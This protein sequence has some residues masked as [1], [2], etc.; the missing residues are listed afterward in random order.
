MI[1]FGKLSEKLKQKLVLKDLFPAIGE[2][3]CKQEV[4]RD[5]VL[6]LLKLGVSVS[7]TE[8]MKNDIFFNY[9]I[10]LSVLRICQ[11]LPMF[12]KLEVAIKVC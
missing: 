3:L 2:L 4:T 8:E 12:I 10:V 5:V 9:Q 11:S 6:L 1:K 7:L